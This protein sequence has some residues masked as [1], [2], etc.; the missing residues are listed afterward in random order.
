MFDLRD[1]VLYWKPRE[2]KPAFNSRF[3]GKPAGH[4]LS[5]AKA[6][7]AY[8][9]VGVKGRYYMAHRII[10]AMLHGSPG[11]LS[12]DHIDGNGLNN[13]P[14]NLRLCKGSTNQRNSR[15]RRDNTS[16]FTGVYRR[17]D[18]WSARINVKRKSIYLGSYITREAA[19]AA[20]IIAERK[21]GFS[22]RHGR[23][24]C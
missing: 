14:E 21:Y 8:L 3:A 9:V 12:I 10:W 17:G 1:G 24:S 19:C 22:E 11:K 4:I 18:K 6:R 5:S 7:T 15:M 2:G 20:R 16:G 23:S 13:S